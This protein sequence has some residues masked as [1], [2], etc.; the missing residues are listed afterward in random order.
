MRPYVL[1]YKAG[2]RSARALANELGCRRIKLRNSRFR[3]TPHRKV[4][5]WGGGTAVPYPVLNEP[6]AVRAA[7][8]K[9]TAF[10]ILEENN[11]SVPEFTTDEQQAHNWIDEG[12][13]VVARTLL[14]A[15]SGRGIVIC[16]DCDDVVAAPL[17]VKYVKKQQEYRVHVF[18]GQ[19]IDVQRKMRSRD[20]PDEDVNWQVRN[21]SNGF[22][23]GR[24]GVVQSPTMLEE[25]R[26]AV[27]ALGLDFGAV[28]IIYSA[29][30]DKWY[31]LEVN[32][33]PGLEGTTLT[34]YANAIRRIL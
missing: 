10:R 28:D 31:V 32:T 16:T 17:Y 9:L 33:A 25:S 7:S 2:S 30:H 6:V 27:A 11:V 23:F 24:E 1:P 34:N 12:S 8:N 14:R 21:H 13:T 20:V 3:H 4:I 29:H 22:I 26:K 5:N 15:N 19:A 18:S